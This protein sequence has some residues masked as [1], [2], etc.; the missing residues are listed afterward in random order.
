MTYKLKEVQVTISSG[1]VV[2]AE[3]ATIADLEQLLS[4]LAGL[5]VKPP[6]KRDEN[7]DATRDA[8]RQ[9]SDDYT[10]ESLVETRAGLS[11]GSL[12][13]KSVLAFKDGIPQLLRP[14]AFDSVAD[15]S[16]ALL[17]AVE[18]G[19]KKNSLEFEAFKGLYE[20][21]NIKSGSPVSMLLTN[22]RNAQYLDG[23]LYAAERKVRL[24]AK[25]EN[26][27]VD[28]LKAQVEKGK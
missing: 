17:F 27:A 23:K 20:S 19:L 4:D 18:A 21:Q 11:S 16:V 22:L 2:T 14:N 1:A 26:K 12:R 3:V 7:H 28:V 15:A 9:H 24:T 8:E 10:P 25:G 13:S 6:P 5:G